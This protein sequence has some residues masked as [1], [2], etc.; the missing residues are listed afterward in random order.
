MSDSANKS[1]SHY[2]DDLKG[3]LSNLRIYVFGRAIESPAQPG[4]ASE[5]DTSPSDLDLLAQVNED[6]R[7]RC[8][9]I[10]NRADELVALR[11]E[12]IDVF[13]E[14][15]KI[16]RDTEG[17]T[18]ALVERSAML[19][20]EEEEHSALKARYRA[21]YDDHE[22][23]NNQVSLLQSEVERSGELVSTRESRIQ[24]V[25]QQLS[26]ERE[27]FATLQNELDQ[28]RY[29]GGLTSE[30]LNAALGDIRADETLLA[31]LQTQV[32]AL[33][34]RSSA[35]EFH[36]SAMEASLSESQVL[37]RGLRDS[38]AE[39]QQ[40]G[41]SL[42]RR[43]DESNAEVEASRSRIETIEATLSS[44]RLEREVAQAVW[45]QKDQAAADEIAGLKTQLDADRARAEAGE[46]QLAE[47]RAE[48]QTTGSE[49]RAKEREAELL[50]AGIAP[51]DERLNSAVEEIASLTDKLAEAERSR[52][53]LADR[54]Q[55]LVRAMTD[56]L[57]KLELAE[58]RAQLLEGRLA[59][60]A[61][62]F[63]ADT[64]QSERKIHELNE[65]FEREKAAR[66]VAAGA[67]EAART[68][69]ARQRE[70]TSLHDVLTRADE[71]ATDEPLMH[72]SDTRALPAVSLGG[73]R[74]AVE[75][76][77]RSVVLQKAHTVAI[78]RE[79]TRRGGRT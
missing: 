1:P 37:V 79:P 32:A 41:E 17:T 50:M 69:A 75:A 22:K 40:N 3:S 54:A 66:V 27:R 5:D 9:G 29:M 68:R 4:E 2:L 31:A 14:V 11:N 53:Q 44:E 34:D 48:L 33:S 58:Q 77:G 16:L 18:S 13:G 39:S 12:F 23:K 59:S 8:I 45:Q 20:L 43:L 52:A 26:D 38:L 62:R 46:A 57:A 73:A 21:L 67:L 64:E 35:A 7:E 28:E 51:L 71:N 15:G 60:E 6:I 61:A 76:P 56:Q 72:R 47:A 25:E 42:S 19:A 36:V 70:A 24:A 65:R 78:K 55:A 49:L 63:A 10:V 74:G 30:K